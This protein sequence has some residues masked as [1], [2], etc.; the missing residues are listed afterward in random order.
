[1]GKA[2]LQNSLKLL[3][4]RMEGD[5]IWA[6]IISLIKKID[7]PILTLKLIR[8]LGGE[9]VSEGTKPCNTDSAPSGTCSEEEEQASSSL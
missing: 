4:M 5:S 8:E 6:E 2:I 7:N 9:E 3:L 1:M